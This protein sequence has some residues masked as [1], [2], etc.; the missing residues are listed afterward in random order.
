[1]PLLSKPQLRAAYNRAPLR[2]AIEEMRHEAKVM[3]D[4]VKA[5]LILVQRQLR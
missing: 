1:M 3:F 4:S 5:D 2:K